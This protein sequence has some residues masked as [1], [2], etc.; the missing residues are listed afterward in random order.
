MDSFAVHR[1]ESTALATNQKALSRD[2]GMVWRDRYELNEQLPPHPS[3]VTELLVDKIFTK[4]FAD[5][6][7]VHGPS[8]IYVFGSAAVYSALGDRFTDSLGKDANRDSPFH[9]I[10]LLIVVPPGPDRE[11]AFTDHIL[12]VDRWTQQSPACNGFWVNRMYNQKLK[13]RY[14]VS[15]YGDTY[16]MSREGIID[17]G[18]RGYVS[19]QIAVASLDI[20]CRAVIYDP[21][22][23]QYLASQR[24]INAWTTKINTVG[25]DRCSDQLLKRLLNQPGFLTRFDPAAITDYEAFCAF[26]ESIVEAVTHVNKAL[27]AV[28]EYTTGTGKSPDIKYTL[29]RA[30][31]SLLMGLNPRQVMAY[32]HCSDIP[33]ES[34]MYSSVSLRS[35]STSID[36]SQLASFARWICEEFLETRQISKSGDQKIAP[37]TLKRYMCE[38]DAFYTMT[39]VQHPLRRVYD[40]ELNLHYRVRR[41]LHCERITI[42]DVK[43]N[44][45]TITVIKGDTNEVVLEFP[46]KVP[47]ER[48]QKHLDDPDQP[49]VNVM[50]SDCACTGCD[51]W[52]LGS[53][54]ELIAAAKIDYSQLEAQVEQLRTGQG[55]AR[56][57]AVRVLKLT[58]RDSRDIPSLRD[59]LRKYTSLEGLINA[60]RTLKE[61]LMYQKYVGDLADDA[62]WVAFSDFRFDFEFTL[63]SF[64]ESLYGADHVA[65]VTAKINAA[66]QPTGSDPN[67]VLARAFPKPPVDLYQVVVKAGGKKW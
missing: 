66:Q 1:L 16:S 61:K 24:F 58:W 26:G 67:S 8:R 54:G 53:P 51:Y 29:Q 28:T 30:K 36:C 22:N 15:D 4:V 40:E 57:Q 12:A 32:A 7:W 2:L 27:E 31:E 44:Y 50:G 17:L 46:F 48:Y 59:D 60:A 33:V 5:F 43:R 21:V 3:G 62:E 23:N 13:F 49:F 55:K 39:D 47:I 63:G 37:V 9:D 38:D 19:P 42:G 6:P 20:D 14:E 18:R 25:A 41:Q 52:D 34:T 65:K 35:G 45:T 10:D 11:Q 64:L 56:T